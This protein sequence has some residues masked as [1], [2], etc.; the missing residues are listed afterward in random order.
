MK[1]WRE[2][3]GGMPEFIQDDKQPVQ[4]IVVNFA[5]REDVQAFADLIGAKFTDKSKTTWFP[6][7]PRAKMTHTAYIDAD[8][9]DA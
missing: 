2:E 1:D 6:V 8:A 9:S 5:T 4:K 7:Q 3:W